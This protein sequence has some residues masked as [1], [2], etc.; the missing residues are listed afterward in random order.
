VYAMVLMVPDTVG[1]GNPKELD[2]SVVDIM[3]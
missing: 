2:V 1:I 3:F